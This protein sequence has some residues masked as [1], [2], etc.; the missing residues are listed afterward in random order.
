[1]LPIDADVVEVER[2]LY[3]DGESQ[4]LINQKRARL[5]DIRDL[6]WIRGSGRTRTR[7]SSRARSMRCC[8]RA[9]RS[10][11]DLRRGRRDRQVQAA[12]DRGAAEARAGRGEPDADAEQLASTERRLKIVKGQAVKARKFKELDAQLRATRMAMTFDQYDDIR[13]RL[14]ALTSS[15]SQLEETRTKAAAMLAEVETAKQESELV[16]HELSQKH[17]SLDE[18]KL[19]AGTRSSRHRNGKC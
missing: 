10:A 7:S 12:P 2:R 18:Q 13:E 14:D 17:K 15:L 8:S 1:M 5:R 9:R 6:F 16:R 11:D 19:A 4:Y 3:R